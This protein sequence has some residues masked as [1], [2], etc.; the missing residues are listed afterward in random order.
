M[1]LSIPRM[2]CIPWLSIYITADNNAC[3]LK[4]L[5]CTVMAWFAKAFQVVGVGKQIPIALMGLDV[6]GHQE[7][8]FTCLGLPSTLLAGKQGLGEGLP[9]QASGLVA[10]EL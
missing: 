2:A 1:W 3:A 10:P 4:G 5:H 7:V 8:C 6:V 9:A